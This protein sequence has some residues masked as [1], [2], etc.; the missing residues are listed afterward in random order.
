VG[1]AMRPHLAG[2]KPGQSVQPSQ[3]VSLSRD[4]VDAEAATTYMN[5]FVHDP[6]MTAVLGLERGIPEVSSVREMLAPKLTE[7]EAITVA[8]FDSVQGHVGPL[9]P[10]PP[11]G[12]REIEEA[13]ERIAV[14][15]LLDRQSIE[16]TANA[17]MREARGILRRA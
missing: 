8:Y 11:P 17:F 10:A 13:F 12:N 7:A 5:A 3:F 2:G 16:D 14:N 1:A 9:P 4:T 6:D 15:I